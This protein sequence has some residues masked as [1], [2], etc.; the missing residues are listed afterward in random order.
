MRTVEGPD[1]GELSRALASRRWAWV[2]V[3]SPEAAAVFCA[4]WGEAGKPALQVAAVGAATKMALEAA[5]VAVRFVPGKATGKAL[6][7]EFEVA[8]G[9]TNA[10]GV[11]V[12]Y[13]ASLLAG[14]VVVEG[15]ARK[16]FRVTRLNTYSTVEA[17]WSEEE[18]ARAREV[19][20]VSFA[21]PSAVKS[22]VGKA[23]IV[24]GVAVACIG[25]TSAA[26]AVSAGFPEANVFFPE[27]PGLGGWVSAVG[28]AIEGRE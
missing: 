20:V 25:E 1:L 27:K 19:D 13:P 12:L 16:G 14:S 21:A 7:E 28:N 2:V 11:D 22:W 17:D 24:D 26:A 15:L 4:K 3:T 23:G 5:G 8:T 9:E 10:G 18:A 6:V